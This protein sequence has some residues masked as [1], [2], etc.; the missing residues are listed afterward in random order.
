ME[1]IGMRLRNF[2]PFYGDDNQL[3]FTKI[4]GAG[5]TVIFGENMKGKTGLFL[6]F[7]W[8]LYGTA[9]G[10]TNDMIPVF[11][12]GAADNN[13]LLN[14]RAAEEADYDVG[15][16]LSFRVD[17][18]TWVLERRMTCSGDATAGDQF[19][20][21]LSLQIG[22]HQ[23]SK[24][25]IDQRINQQL[26]HKAAQFYFFDGEL[27]SQY[28][29]W[30]EN[31]EERQDRVQ[32]AIENIVGIAA[33]QL[34]K[35]MDDVARSF[36]AEQQKLLRK[37]QRHERLADELKALEEDV[38]RLEAEI[39]NYED[40]E[41]RL[42]RE[43]DRIAAIH[44]ELADFKEMQ[45]QLEELEASID[46]ERE[47]QEEAEA[48][49]RRL[50]RDAYW[51]PVATKT[52]ALY[53]QL[54]GDLRRSLAA[55][56]VSAKQALVLESAE[57]GIC[58][59]CGNDL[60]SKECSRL[61][62][63]AQDLALSAFDSGPVDDVMEA[64]RRIDEAVQ[65]TAT[66]QTELLVKIDE[67]R[68]SARTEIFQREEKAKSIRAEHSDRPRGERE[69]EMARMQEIANNQGKAAANRREAIVELKGKKEEL[70][71]KQAQANR[72]SIDKTVQ[73]KA[74]TARLA[75]NATANALSSFREKARIVVEQE[76]GKIFSM[77]LE[78]PEYVGLRI[79]GDYRVL[80]VDQNGNVLPVPSAG[81]QQILTLALLGGLNAAA[82]HRAP[83]VMDT[84]AGR[85]D[86]PNRERIMRWIGTREDQTVLMVHSGEYT[87]EE[88]RQIG[89]PVAR[90]YEIEA[91][92][93]KT[94]TISPVA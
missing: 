18:E 74:L 38:R 80:P 20:Q 50:T 63:D 81:G 25:D 93:H 1:L 94:S 59:I 30:L 83:V 40:E 91:V 68:E 17:D 36:E 34:A 28:E 42:G 23:V 90:M 82:V 35:S 13:Y 19:D 71:K 14:A 21:H 70:A 5:L 11:S 51:L 16:E 26:H 84:P 58:S 29:A 27:L 92:G 52:E 39:L 10:R 75:A 9:V 49:A 89:V 64:V 66:G 88:I 31:P 72:V 53:D 33:L 37:E 76:A 8:C 67:E 62:K 78:D 6:A 43:A 15:V 24:G 54:M 2:R 61:R 56:E 4:N 57:G 44:G 32:A 85:I 86:R 12:P 87:K 55:G 69:A 48:N 65:F 47:R 45:G 79:D 22:D 73:Q 41:A 46:I 7:H 77:L 3:D 60:S